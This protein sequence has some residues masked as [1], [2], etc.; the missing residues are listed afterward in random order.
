MAIPECEALRAAKLSCPLRWSKCYGLQPPYPSYFEERAPK[1]CWVAHTALTILEAFELYTIAGRALQRRGLTGGSVAVAALLHDVGKLSEAYLMGD[2]VF[3][4]IT[5]ALIVLRVCG[6]ELM[7]ARAIAQAV[8]LHHE[9]RMWE[10]LSSSDPVEKAF[11]NS[12]DDLLMEYEKRVKFVKFSKKSQQYEAL[13][14]AME[15]LMGQ[16]SDRFEERPD[17]SLISLLHRVPEHL[18]INRCEDR[19][20]L[21]DT[22][23]APRSLPLYYILQLADNRA[24]WRRSGVDWRAELRRLTSERSS[25]LELA[26]KMLRDYGS[27]SRLFLTLSRANT[28]LRDPKGPN[29]L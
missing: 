10:Y 8:M 14:E 19:N 22:S 12:Y 21:L 23:L 9:H 20:V 3:H 6:K 11:K 2:D 27:R 16:I 25:P 18:T 29:T 26:T 24:A 28:A 13:L 7:E 5:S 17:Q 4:N 1:G 15:G